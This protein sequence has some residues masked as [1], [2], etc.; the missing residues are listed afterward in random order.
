MQVEIL[1]LFLSR[2]NYSGEAVIAQIRSDAE[3]IVLVLKAAF[4]IPLTGQPKTAHCSA[5]VQPL[6]KL[7]RTCHQ[8]MSNVDR[9]QKV[10]TN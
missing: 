3:L 2:E 9:E 6:T 1:L 4:G 10:S 5:V 8:A 7:T